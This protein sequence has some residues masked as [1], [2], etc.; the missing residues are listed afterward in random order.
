MR[1]VLFVV[2]LAALT[3]SWQAS[4]SLRAISLERMALKIVRGETYDAQAFD[5]ALAQPSDGCLPRLQRAELLLRAGSVDASIAAGALDRIDAEM[6]ALGEA[7]DNL[8]ACS[9]REGFGWLMRFWT[10]SRHRGLTAEVLGDL[11]RSYRFAPREPW[12]SARRNP[13]AMAIYARLPASLQEAIQAE[14]REMVGAQLYGSA[15]E[16]L[17]LAKPD[18]RRQLLAGLSPLNDNARNGFARALRSG[19]IEGAVPGLD[20]LPDRPWFRF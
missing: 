9:P 12:I 7:A 15:I 3:W 6:Q 17:I 13:V 11:G 10:Q 1:V 19:R 14:F 8:L 4:A 18:V 2:A 16:T 5:A 20:P